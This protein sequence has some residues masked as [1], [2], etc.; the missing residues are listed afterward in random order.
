MYLYACTTS[1]HNAALQ[2]RHSYE[3]TEI[4]VLRATLCPRRDLVL[5]REREVPNLLLVPDRQASPSK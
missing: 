5:C 1:R 3:I 2:V 4:R